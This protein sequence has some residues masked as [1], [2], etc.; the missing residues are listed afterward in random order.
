M[1]YTFFLLTQSVLICPLSPQIHAQRATNSSLLPTWTCP[2]HNTYDN[3]QILSPMQ[4]GTP[5]PLWI[6]ICSEPQRTPRHSSISLRLCYINKAT[7]IPWNGCWAHPSTSIEAGTEDLLQ[8]D[9]SITS[10]PPWYSSGIH[11]GISCKNRRKYTS[12]AWIHSHSRV[13][14]TKEQGKL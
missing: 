10:L 14:Y 8:T 2:F 3:A 13:G 4:Q 9:A 1:V 11:L 7:W 12:S 6:F 5:L